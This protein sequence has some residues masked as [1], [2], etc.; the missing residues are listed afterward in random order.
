MG[1]LAAALALGASQ[2]DKKDWNFD[3]DRTGRTA[4][5]FRGEIGDWKVVAAGDAPSK[6]NVLAQLAKN[7]GSA[8]NISLASGTAY[9]DLDLTVKMKAVAG[10]EDQGGG[11][12]WR[13][14]DKGNYY[15][16]R[17]NP[18][19]DNFRVYKVESGRRTQFGDASVKGDAA[20]H[21]MRVTM[22]G[23]RIECFLDGKK[24]LDAR[25]STFKEAGMIG[26]WTKA[27]AQ[28][29]FDD[30]SVKPAP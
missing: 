15:V 16:A 24:H 19:E 3:A 23:E 5:G 26:L 9:G 14:K 7:S 29:H 6:P 2:G 8:Y 13:A 1:T 28:T 27:D 30:L 18:L 10:K 21:T 22:K 11:L 17:F 12:V 4:P 20:W 25:D